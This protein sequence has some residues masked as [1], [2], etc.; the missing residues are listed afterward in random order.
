MCIRGVKSNSSLTLHDVL[1]AFQTDE[2]CY[3]DIVI[4]GGEPTMCDD[5]PEIVS[6]FSKHA[7]SVAICTNGTNSELLLSV[8][9]GLN[10]RVQVSI[11][12]TQSIHDS[13]RG[14]G[15]YQMAINTVA[16][17]DASNVPYTIA[18]VVS[19]RNYQCMP[20][21]SKILESY[22]RLCYWALSFEMPFGNSDISSILSCDEWNMFV[23]NILNISN[24]RTR[25]K[26]L[27]PFDLYH[28]YA[29]LLDS[30]KLGKW[31]MNC[32][33]GSEKIYIYPDLTVYPCTCLTDFPLGNLGHSSL[34]DILANEKAQ[35]FSN[36]HI[37]EESQCNS[38]EFL[39]YCNGG[40]MGMSYHYFNKLGM[41]DIRCP[42]V[43]LSQRTTN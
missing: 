41:G 12:G 35:S 1:S 17:L 42:K 16:L 43:Q 11:D 31:C 10:V 30:N 32:G 26:K 25:V 28:K 14:E 18:T 33:S 19:K 34:H 9:Y 20:E 5:F 23:D 6:F 8:H 7:K 21:L 37:R 40:C 27:F 22:K 2:L 29:E 38:C 3:Y 4:T 36:Y 15:S 13:I 39:K 24:I